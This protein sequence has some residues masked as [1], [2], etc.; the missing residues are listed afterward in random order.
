MSLLDQQ[1]QPQKVEITIE[2]LQ[3]LLEVLIAGDVNTAKMWLMAAI[4]QAKQDVRK[5]K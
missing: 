5:K 3:S 4:R 1:P 2:Q